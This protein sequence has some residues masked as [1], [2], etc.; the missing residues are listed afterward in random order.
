[1]Y[2]MN[3]IYKKEIK[4]EIKKLKKEWDILQGKTI[5]ITGAAGMIG[6][7]ITDLIM[8]ANAE[9]GCNIHVLALVRNIEKAKERF[10][11]YSC[12]HGL[13]I[14]SHDISEPLS[15]KE[16]GRA[17]YIIHAA[18]NTHPKEYSSDPVGTITANVIGMRNI[19]EYVRCNSP[20][21]RVVCLSSVEIYGDNSTQKDSF[22]EKD[23]GYIDCN[24]LRAGYPE[25][26]RLCETMAQAYRKQYEIDTVIARLCRIYGPALAPD[27]SKALTQFLRNAAAGRDIEL[28]SNG[29]QVYSYS[30]IADAASA[31]L[32]I[33]CTGLTGEAY[34]VASPK[35]DM[36]LKDIAE[37]LA[38]TAGTIVVHKTPED[39]EMAG[40]SKAVRAVI[41]TDKIERELGWK[42]QYDLQSGLDQTLKIL[43]EKLD[44]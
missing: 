8:E 21:C 40:Y 22:S 28:K 35:G 3:E 17:D 23:F 10:A 19:Y 30:Y 32:M 14:F 31:I 18:S 16:I 27:D 24:S 11:G 42:P 2:K 9:Y 33:M 20:G 34:N 5:L 41:D 37:F 13:K 7:Y 38:D 25:S 12:C 1:M 4:D 43:K 44:D 36:C 15:E 39:E 26:K 6:G 29:N